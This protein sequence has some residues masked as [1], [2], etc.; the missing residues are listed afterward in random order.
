M[1]LPASVMAELELHLA[2]F[3]GEHYVSPDPLAV[4]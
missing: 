2:A 4:R 3:A 1:T